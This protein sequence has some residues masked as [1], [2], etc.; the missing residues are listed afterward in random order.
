[1]SFGDVI[2]SAGS[3]SS[4]PSGIGG[5]SNTIWH[6]DKN[7]DRIYELNTVDFSVIRSSASPG[8]NPGDVGGDSNTIWHCENIIYELSTVDFSVIRSGSLPGYPFGVGGDSNVIWYSSYA[9]GAKLYELSTIDFS[10]IKSRSSV[11]NAKGIGGT[12]NAIWHCDSNLKRIY[13]LSTVDLSVIQYTSAPATYPIGIGGNLNTIWHCD[14]LARRVYE[15][16]SDVNLPPVA[17]CNGPYEGI[18]D[19]AIIFDGSGSID[20]DGTIV[21]Y[22]WDFGD[23]KTGVGVNANH[24]YTVADTYTVVLTVTDD[25]GLTDDDTTVA[26]ISEAVAVDDSIPDAFTFGR[27]GKKRR[28]RVEV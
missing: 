9:V 16:D 13:E 15:L 14:N 27:I 10:V 1:M 17:N 8:S 12:T 19:E 5:D 24:T 20:P 25:G 3:P 22:E 26:T 28:H 7:V 11:W 21:L 23:S 2:R 6:A 4:E 18:T